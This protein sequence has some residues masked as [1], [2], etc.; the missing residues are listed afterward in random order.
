MRR[1]IL[2]LAPVLGVLGVIGVVGVAAGVTARAAGT[3]HV[4]IHDGLVS[5]SAHNATLRDILDA[6]AQAGQTTIVN[7]EKV[8]A[9]TPMTMDLTDV[10]ETQALDIVLRSL[11]GYLAVPRSLSRPSA[12]RYDRIV[13][14]PVSAVSAAD[15]DSA[16][17]A[18]APPFPTPFVL[19]ALPPEV[20]PPAPVIA[21]AVA[22][23]LGSSRGDAPAPVS[24][25]PAPSSA[26]PA[27]NSTSGAMVGSS[28]P[29]MIVPAQ[30]P[31]GAPVQSAP[32]PR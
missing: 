15:R 19:P 12:S 5:V 31:A 28:V 18:A 4:A 10:P 2:T 27:Q 30:P 22:A 8:T 20:A 32:P 29:G 6:Y 14:V 13:I 16:R 21:P 24:L 11:S 1:R 26:T 25:S 3:V 17:P 7:V 23:P 9:T